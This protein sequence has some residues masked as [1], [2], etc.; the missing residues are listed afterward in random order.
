MDDQPIAA[1]FFGE[2]KWLT[3]FITPVNLD[4]Q[5]A[6]QELTAGLTSIE[7]KIVACQQYIGRMTYKKLISGTINIEGRVSHQKDLWS[8]P[9]TT[10]AIGIGNCA[11]KSFLLASL[12]RNQ[13]PP[14]QIYC[15]LGNLHNGKTG[16]HAWVQVNLDQEYIVES[17]RADIPPM[18]LA[19][20]TP[21][22][23]AVHFFND[24]ETYAIGGRTVLEPFTACYSTWLVDY[25]D[26]AYIKGKK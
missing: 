1:T 7:D 9:S 8:D 19:E 26:W 12:L 4:I 14:D 11:N 21:R 17:T 3:E 15:V 23:E 18:V 25:L 16:G 22:Y 24:K 10:L 2:G 6:Y 13:L 20:S 5:E